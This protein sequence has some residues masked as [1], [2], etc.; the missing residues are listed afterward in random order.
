MGT[1]KLLDAD[2]LDYEAFAALQREAFAE[3][4]ERAGSTA[5]WMTPELYRW[6]YHP[7]AGNALIAVV[8][9]GDDLVAANAMFPLEI[10][11]GGDAVRGWQSCDTATAPRGRGQGYF[12]GCLHTLG[13]ALQP[14]EIFFGF[15]N[16]NSMRGFEKVGWTSRGLV[17][18]WVNPLSLLGRGPTAEI[19]PAEGFAAEYDALADQLAS[20]GKVHVARSA[21]YLDW[22]YTR[23]PTHRYQTFACRDEQ[24]LAG[25]VVARTARAMNR[26]VS[27]VMD[28][29]G[30]RPGVERRLL[31]RVSA[32]ARQQRTRTLVL[33]DTG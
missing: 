9:E 26:D 28:L 15:P 13:E 27:V 18:T 3:V 4:I 21:A 7:P 25:F 2:D 5:D 11:H 23:H 30:S 33:L 6:K 31:R 29:W 24:G 19:Q 22:R 20:S 8:Y 1:F 12:V 10:R 32:W 16:H 17:T 14:E